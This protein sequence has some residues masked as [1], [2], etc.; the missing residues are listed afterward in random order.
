MTFLVSKL[1]SLTVLKGV[2]SSFTLELPPYRAPQVGKVIVRS[3]LDRTLYVLARAIAVAAPAGLIIWIFA[4]VTIGEQTLLLHCTDVLDPIGRFMGL[5]GVIL[6][7]FILAIPANEIVIPIIL[8]A[9]SASGYLIEYAGLSELSMI[10]RANGWT[11]LTA[12]CVIIF[13]LCHFPCSTTLITIKKESGS[14]RWA[15]LAAILPT[16]IGA[17]FCITLNLLSKLFI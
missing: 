3:I 13:M 17:G 1:L 12:V 4:N 7:A 15:I 14:L 2:P 5:D 11:A 9:Y 6:F 16:V 10:L 8:M